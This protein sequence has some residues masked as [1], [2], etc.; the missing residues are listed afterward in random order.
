MTDSTQPA[1]QPNDERRKELTEHRRH[2]VESLHTASQ[3]FD[4]AIMTLA[5]GAL[6]ISI[7]FV[8]QVAPHPRYTAWLGGAWVL[9]AASLVCILMSFIASQTAIRWEISHVYDDP[10]PERPHLKRTTRLN[11]IS[12][13]LFV[14]GVVS[15]V[16]FAFMNLG[17]VNV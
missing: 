16:V 15:L 6:G 1:E 7:A 10:R 14:L 9:F 12:A 5:A 8:N 17:R 2:L 4:K 3:D 13:T 11:T